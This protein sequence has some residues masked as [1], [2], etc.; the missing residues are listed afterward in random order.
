M[1]IEAFE[2]NNEPLKEAI[3]NFKDQIESKKTEIQNDIPR[4]LKIAQA[5]LESKIVTAQKKRN[6]DIVMEIIRTCEGGVDPYTGERHNGFEGKIRD[7]FNEWRKE[8][9]WGK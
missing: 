2:N 3:S 4:K 9:R 5:Q 7:T 8:E 1:I 6:R